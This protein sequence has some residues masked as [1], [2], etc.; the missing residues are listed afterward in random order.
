[1]LRLKGAAWMNDAGTDDEVISDNKKAEE[2]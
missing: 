1:V 2:E